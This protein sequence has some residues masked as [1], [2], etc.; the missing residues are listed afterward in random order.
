MFVGSF[1]KEKL[2]RKWVTVKERKS[3]RKSYSNELYKLYDEPCVT[4]FYVGKVTMG[5]I[6]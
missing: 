5:W 2:R 3:W 1:E 6:G 4:D